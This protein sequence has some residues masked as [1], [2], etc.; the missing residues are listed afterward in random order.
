M[1]KISDAERISRNYQLS[2][3]SNMR[4]LEIFNIINIYLFYFAIKIDR[5]MQ[6]YLLNEAKQIVCLEALL[7]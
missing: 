1:N 3:M 4:L 5:Y 7:I 2:E 6:T